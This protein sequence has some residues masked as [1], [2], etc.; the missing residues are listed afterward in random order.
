VRRF[1]AALSLAASLALPAQAQPIQPR[2]ARGATF[3]ALWAAY[4]RADRAGDAE[5]ANKVFHE[6]RRLRLERNIRSLEPIALALVARGLDRLGKGEREGAEE[7]FRSAVGLDPHLPD[8][9]FGLARVEL[10]KGP[11]GLLPAARETL[12]GV[13]ARRST[14]RGRYQ[15]LLFLVPVA[16]LGLF[17]VLSVVSLALLLRHGPLLRHDLQEA[18]G[19]GRG[20]AVALAFFVCLLLIP[21]V[22]FQGWAWLPLW[23]LA[24]LF[25]YLRWIE[26]VVTL[27]ML[28]LTVSVGPLVA[29]LELRTQAARN[30]LYWAGIQA[31]E[32]AADPR[33]IAALETAVQRHPDDRDFAYLLA[34]QYKRAGRSEEAATLLRE[35]LRADPQDSIARNNLANADFVRGDFAGALAR[36]KQAAEAGGPAEIVATLYYNQSQAHLQMFEYQPA[37]EARSQAERLAGGLVAEYDRV[38]RYDMGGYVV[39]DLSLAPEQLEAKFAG[40]PDGVGVKNLARERGS[41]D[42]GTAR[43]AAAAI[44]RFA[45]FAAVFAVVAFGFAA[46]R[47]RRAFTMHCQKCGTAFCRRCHLGVVVGGLCSQCHHLFV[48]RDGVSGPARNRKLLEVQAEDER[49]G[50][51]FRVLSLLSPGA[52]H[53]YAEKTLLGLLFVT[54]WYVTLA[55]TLLAGRLPVTE[56]PRAAAWRWGLA[57]A[58]AL[59]GA[60]YVLANRL[61]PDFE[62]EGAVPRSLTRREREA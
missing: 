54:V 58:A 20:G 25:V 16:V 55:A 27:L 51:L 2:P 39:V 12:A 56:A 60:T 53:I 30:P 52:G 26:K 6:I 45:G 29:V 37:Q 7:L 59:L 11:L 49:R 15:L 10:R 38:G 9:Y 46:R 8:A 21:A 14:A 5:G 17:T 57:L 42:S 19:T 36:Y 47:G 48:V 40:T 22:T 33:S 43:L 28:L 1:L 3:E 4:L 18:V 24:L 34:A 35:T 13:L 50:R 23:A 31:V 62:A 41:A 32:S 44:N 61:R